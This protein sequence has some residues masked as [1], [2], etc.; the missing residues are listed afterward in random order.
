M[1][2]CQHRAGGDASHG[3]EQSIE[4]RKQESQ[5]QYD[6]IRD[7][8]LLL[9]KHLPVDHTEKLQQ[10]FHRLKYIRIDQAMLCRAKQHRQEHHAEHYQNGNDQPDQHIQEAGPEDLCRFH[11]QSEGKVAFVRIFVFIEAVQQNY[12]H[13]NGIHAQRHHGEE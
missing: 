13:R 8:V 3:H 9:Q 12:L 11:R 10:V 2:L 5:S 6:Q 4:R 7:A 1:L